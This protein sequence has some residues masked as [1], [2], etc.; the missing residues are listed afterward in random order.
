MLEWHEG[1]FFIYVLLHMYVNTSFSARSGAMFG[2]G[3]RP[4]SSVLKLHYV[5]L[6]T[7]KQQQW[8][9]D[10]KQRNV[11]CPTDECLNDITQHTVLVISNT[12]F[13][14]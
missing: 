14:Q 13:L 8:K 12:T 11:K 9:K 4:P 3:W 5:T 2:F 6:F 1:Y 7:S 10:R